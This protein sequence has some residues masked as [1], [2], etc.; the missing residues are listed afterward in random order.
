MDTKVVQRRIRESLRRPPVVRARSS[1]PAGR[2]D[3][4]TSPELTDATE[5]PESVEFT[6]AADSPEFTDTAD[7]PEF[8]DTADS[9]EFTD[10]AGVPTELWVTSFADLIAPPA[11]PTSEAPPE[12]GHPDQEPTDLD[13]PAR[14]RSVLNDFGLDE[15][16]VESLTGLVES[17]AT[18]AT[19]DEQPSVV[20]RGQALLSSME[21]SNATAGRLDAVLL[22]A[23]RELT[24][25]QGQMLLLDKGGTTPDDLTPT[26]W[27]KWRA[28]A[29]RATR[30]EVEALMGWCPGE[31]SDLVA[32]ANLPASVTAPVAHSLK[33]GESTWRLVRR[34]FR[35][36][37]TFSTEDSAAV[38]NGLFGDDPAASVSERLDSAGEFLGG[39]WRHREFYR[40]LD[41]EVHKIKG[42][43]PQSTK[44]T[45]EDNLAANDT[46][47]LV[48]DNGTAQV[49]IGCT[50][51]Q[52]AAVADRIDKAARAAR[53]AGDPRTLCQLR[54]AA[55]IALLLHGTADLTGLPDDPALVTVEQSEQ[56]TK[57]LHGLPAAQLNVIVPLNALI[58]TTP[59]GM[60]PTGSSPGT[61]VDAEGNPIPAAFATAGA[62]PGQS[63]SRPS[64]S[65]GVSSCTCECTCGAETASDQAPGDASRGQDRPDSGPPGPDCPPQQAASGTQP[66]TPGEPDGEVGVGEVIG[67]HSVFL[68]PD[69][70]RTLAL[71]PG[72]TMYRLLT[73]PAT[74]VLVERSIKAYPFDAGMRAHII[75]ADVFCR[76]PGCLKPA[77]V[78]QIDHVQEHG[79]PGGHTCIA[80]GQPLDTPDHDL[81]TKKLWDA[82]I[83]ANRDVTWTTLL[84]RIYTTKAHDYNQYTKLL[85]AATTQVH[86]AIASGDDPAAA[87]DAAVYQA[88]S[89][90]PAGAKLEAEDDDDFSELFTGWDSVTLTH[91]PESG[92]RTYHPAPDAMR[93][94][95]QRHHDTDDR[96]THDQQDTEDD[97]TTR[98]DQQDTGHDESAGATGQTHRGQDDQTPGHS[99]GSEQPDDGPTTPWTHDPDEPPPF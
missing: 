51:T 63:G 18:V 31:V 91:T 98:A 84:G 55:G 95:A 99:T 12:Q 48:E 1:R 81:K 7:S 37:S 2:K 64:G 30:K 49:M 73:D 4:S 59:G 47:V 54:A 74:G 71:T 33:S 68:S 13:T 14:L 79:T 16:M 34:Y 83:H 40:A 77:S 5:T 90:R 44:K 62:T 70:V 43:D 39:P 3:P 78:A 94:E 93:A 96:V 86:E 22:S 15:S 11:K 38:A 45:R 46:R 19:V 6:D 29:K 21:S 67:K 27:E 89:Y 32:V 61:S 26:Q 76:M 72:S 65:G 24:A 52:G 8:T 69:E 82:V 80:N 57:I 41:R 58:G 50:A 25:V 35:A 23:T 88:L 60:T 92:R 87:V 75:A 28:Q 36:C 17:C 97:Q 66:P 9:P 56:L 53:K 85:T 20:A 42:R 10:A